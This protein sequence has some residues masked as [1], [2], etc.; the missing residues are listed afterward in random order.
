M[1]HT[2][3]HTDCFVLGGVNT[4]E[5]DRF[6]WLFTRDFGLLG[7]Q[8]KSLRK[9]SSKQRPALQDFSCSHVSLVKG[10]SMWRLTN[11]SAGENLYQ[12]YRGTET[13]LFLARLF[14]FLKRMINGEEENRAL[15]SVIEKSLSEA[16]SLDE[17]DI[18]ILETLTYLRCLYLLGYVE[19]SAEF[20]ELLDNVEDFSYEKVF[21]AGPLT[22]AVQNA[23]DKAL[24]ESQL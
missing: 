22:G 7:V 2:K 13:G 12:R 6:L 21:L 23:I 15:Y 4:G 19:K 14:L 17:N 9:I 20:A 3:Y 1:S 11:V 24:S 10:R 18:R 8:T 16:S 5:A